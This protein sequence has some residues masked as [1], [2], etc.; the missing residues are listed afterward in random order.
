MKLDLDR[1]LPFFNK[2]QWVKSKEHPNGTT[3]DRYHALVQSFMLASLM[4]SRKK[5]KVYMT[6]F[7][8]K[9]AGPVVTE[10]ECGDC[11][12]HDESADV[13]GAQ[14]RN[15]ERALANLAKH[16][17][18]V[19]NPHIFSD[20]EQRNTGITAIG[21]PYAGEFDGQT[22]DE[23]AEWDESFK[24]RNLP[25]RQFTVAIP[26]QYINAMVKKKNGSPPWLRAAFYAAYAMVHE[27]GHVI[28]WHNYKVAYE[29]GP[30]GDQ[31]PR[32]GSDLHGE[33]GD[34][35]MARVFDGW[36]IHPIS[37]NDGQDPPLDEK[38]HNDVLS[39]RTGLCCMKQPRIE[40]HPT[41]FQKFRT[42]YSIG[43]DLLSAL[44][45]EDFFDGHVFFKTPFSS[46]VAC[47]RA[48]TLILGFGPVLS[49]SGYEDPNWRDDEVRPPVLNWTPR[50][51]EFMPREQWVEEDLLRTGAMGM[52][53]VL[54]SSLLGILYWGCEM[55][56][57]ITDVFRSQFPPH[58]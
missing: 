17:F 50:P 47:R 24:R 44:F 41:G 20:I 35:L 39:F 57:R 27:I 3:D 46:S 54:M 18:W 52:S 2:R 43:T 31:E 11:I 34:A 37:L 12:Q 26:T 42:Y 32:V 21:H 48:E 58:K 10:T 9:P 6:L 15:A 4:L 49:N 8:G 55:L 22:A 51:H 29:G 45:T 5:V 53:K 1:I 28:F 16:V 30:Q 56:R 25:N 7:L 33:L 23:I 38:L 40:D 13:G 14:I 19:E 36:L